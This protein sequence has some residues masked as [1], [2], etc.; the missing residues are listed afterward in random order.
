MLAATFTDHNGFKAVYV[1]SYAR[2]ATNTAASFVPASLGIPGDAYV[3]DY[4]NH[5]GTIVPSG[6][7]FAFTTT[8]PDANTGGSYFIVVPIGPSGLALLGDTNKYVS[9]GKKRI[10]DLSDSGVLSATIQFSTSE[11]NLTL[12]GYAPA[13]PFVSAPIGTVHSVNYDAAKHWFTAIVAPG[14]L[15][16]ATATLSLRPILQADLQP[17][18]LLLSW[19]STPAT[20]LEKATT[21]SSPA[22]WAPATNAI[23]TLGS[24][25]IATV[26][27][28]LA[29]PSSASNNKEESTLQTVRPP[30][31]RWQ[32]SPWS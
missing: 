18:R 29:P 7:L 26:D 16:S 10:S 23:T 21:L 6:N 5:T 32:K 8:L 27:T 25:N 2:Q 1:F 30:R 31:K 4:F 22:D 24:R 28:A 9:L 19:P 12:S 17:G 15:Q 11:T 13:I 20:V 14:P 3:Y